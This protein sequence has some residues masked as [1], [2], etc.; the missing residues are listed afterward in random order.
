M[1]SLTRLALEK[2]L[3]NIEECLLPAYS[4]YHQDRATDELLMSDPEQFRETILKGY[5]EKLGMLQHEAKQWITAVLE[6]EK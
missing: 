5:S 3:K 6:S 2:A 1:N 4:I